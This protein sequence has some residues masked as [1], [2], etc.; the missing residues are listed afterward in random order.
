MGLM[1]FARMFYTLYNE[2]P[3]IGDPVNKEKIV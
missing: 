2:T 1:L 3:T